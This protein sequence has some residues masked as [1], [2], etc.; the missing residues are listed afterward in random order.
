VSSAQIIF[1][2]FQLV[3]FSPINF[4]YVSGTAGIF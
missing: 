1:F 4:L 2:L 3:L